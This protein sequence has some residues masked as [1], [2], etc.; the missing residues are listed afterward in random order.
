MAGRFIEVEGLGKQYESAAPD[1]P[2]ALDAITLAI[3]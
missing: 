3:D 2:P 1:T